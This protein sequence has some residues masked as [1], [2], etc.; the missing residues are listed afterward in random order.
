MRGGAARLLQR[1]TTRTLDRSALG[2]YYVRY[3]GS[4]RQD[5]DESQA[6]GGAYIDCWVKAQTE[7][8][9]RATAVRYIEDQA[10]MVVSVEDGPRVVSRPVDETSEYFDQ[11]QTDGACYVF[12]T[13][14]IGDHSEES[15]H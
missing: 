4:P 12:H 13:W 6:I 9:A 3:E 15:L 11:A 2:I 14:P 8:E 5:S 7:E 10:W 1:A